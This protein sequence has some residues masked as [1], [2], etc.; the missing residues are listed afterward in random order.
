MVLSGNTLLLP[1][2]TPAARNTVTLGLMLAFTDG[3]ELF[4]VQMLKNWPLVRSEYTSMTKPS[5]RK[6]DSETLL[7]SCS[8]TSFNGTRH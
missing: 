3:W 1:F 6:A 8:G 5:E 4:P 7:P 2:T